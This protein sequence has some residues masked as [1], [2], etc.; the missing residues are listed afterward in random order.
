MGSAGR[1]PVVSGG[2]LTE[3]MAGVGLASE[4]VFFCHSP[5]RPEA[6]FSTLIKRVA[7][8]VAL[9]DRNGYESVVAL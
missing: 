2:D 3:S 6:L 5:D 8:G 4:R 9:A 7:P 1:V